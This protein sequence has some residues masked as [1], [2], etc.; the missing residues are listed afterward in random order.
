MVHTGTALASVL[1]TA[2]TGRGSRLLPHPGRLPQSGICPGL[3]CSRAFPPAADQPW[4]A[5]LRSP[6][7]V[8]DALQAADHRRQ[9]DVP[10]ARLL[11]K[12]RGCPP[13]PLGQAHVP[14]ADPH[15]VGRS[16][17]GTDGALDVAARPC[18]FCQ[19]LPSALVQTRLTDLLNALAV[20]LFGGPGI[21]SMATAA[22]WEAVR[23]RRCWSA[24]SR[25]TPGGGTGKGS[26]GI[27]MGIA[28]ASRGLPA[29]AVPLPQC[30][31]S[32]AFAVNYGG[33]DVH[34]KE[35]LNG[36]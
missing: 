32:F 6:G 34:G 7:I 19:G 17:P 31:G 28:I 25:A 3:V 14:V 20:D 24:A 27:R 36:V 29:S 5:A 22:R 18:H 13:D 30:G 21:R 35:E 16:G 11:G 26:A 15:H 10:H 9:R 1:C 2:P 4:L 8:D 12:P 33:H 23:S